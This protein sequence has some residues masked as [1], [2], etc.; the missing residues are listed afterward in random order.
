MGV[1]LK[2][3]YRHHP[4]LRPYYM[5]NEQVQELAWNVRVQIGYASHAHLRIPIERFLEIEDATV[6]G[7][8][9]DF[10]WDI[11]DRVLDERRT[12]VLGIC[13]YDPDGLPNVSQLSANRSMV[14]GRSSMLRGILTHELGHGLCDAPAWIVGHQ[15]QA[16]P[17]IL[18]APQARTSAVT[19]NQE[20]LLPKRNVRPDFAEYRANE[21]M[22]TCLVPRQ[23]LIEPLRYYARIHDVALV[24]VRDPMD[25]PFG[26]D[27]PGL[28]IDACGDGNERRCRY[29]LFRALADEFGVTPRFIHV[30]L[31]RYGLADDEDSPAGMA[32]SHVTAN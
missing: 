28:R 22:G 15:Q 31:M 14:Q 32:R 2:A 6:N 7:V 21:F 4:D 9:Y 8:S 20:H 30:R 18:D 5:T 23:L 27:V 25:L 16:L 19:P 13:D 29:Q 24:E 11:A 17:G 12:P 26:N 10:I 3:A 1:R